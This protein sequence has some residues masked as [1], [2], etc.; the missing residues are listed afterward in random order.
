MKKT[1][2]ITGCM[3]AAVV[4]LV[5]CG[6]PRRDPGHAYM[7]D[8]AYSNAY[9]T[10][11]PAEERLKHSEAS[12]QPHFNGS[13]VPGTVA[14][15]ELAAYRLKNDTTGYAQSVAIH[16]P[17][18]PATID[19]KEAERLYLVNCGVCHGAALD[20]NGPLYDN[21]EGPYQAAP[22]N[23]MGEDMK[24]QPEGQTF[25]VI[26][27]GKNAMGSYASQLTSKQR[28]M[29]VAYVKS[30]QHGG[31]SNRVVAD[32]TKATGAGP[33]STAAGAAKAK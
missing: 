13:P 27:Y 33:D 4:L 28:W 14:R 29:V 11:A 5:S 16:N 3:T 31:A 23:L 21:G 32:T 25:H 9:E 30:K 8:M 26:T 19:M 22:K 6:G 1:L 2:I 20:G 17:L 10:Y 12:S 18:D 15:G 7:P 24:A